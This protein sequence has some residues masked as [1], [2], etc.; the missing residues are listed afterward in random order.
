VIASLAVFVLANVAGAL[1]PS[2]PWLLLARVITAVAAAAFTPAASAAAVALAGPARRGR[3][4]S[5]ITGGLAV[6][7]VFGVPAGTA[8]GQHL[9]WP[10]SLI[11]IA[12]VALIALAALIVRLPALP[13]PPAVALADR[14]R[15]L[16]NARV[17]LLVAV[18]AV[19]TTGGIMFYTYVAFVLSGTAGLTGSSLAIVLVAW[20]I[21]GSLGA[22]G[23]GWAADRF[24]PD[25]VLL[26]GLIALA[27]DVAALGFAG[28]LGLVL[29]LALIGG[30]ASWSLITPINHRLT[31]LAPANP[32]VVISLNSSGSYLGQALGAAIGGVVIAGG[33][34]ARTVCVGGA[35][36]VVVALLLE[37]TAA[38]PVT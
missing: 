12:A 30:A 22:F 17:L 31:G 13:L 33:A 26:T 5:A 8:I 2:L 14:L 20:G 3:A 27:L 15:L 18:N 32:G 19:A 9:G 4:L 37:R 28:Q 23:A 10:A 7:T 24:G 21:G 29:P 36:I 16:V 6:G 11:F 35:L 1:A 34:S 25:R 38:R